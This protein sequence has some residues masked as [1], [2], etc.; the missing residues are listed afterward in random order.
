MEFNFD[1]NEKDYKK[2][3]ETGAWLLEQAMGMNI[4]EVVVN[5][6]EGDE[7]SYIQ[8]LLADIFSESGISLKFK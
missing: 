6:S 5:I 2:I 8:G 4:D 3:S 7:K 1:G